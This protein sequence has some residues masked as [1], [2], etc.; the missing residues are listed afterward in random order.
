MTV[1][2]YSATL[3]PFLSTI[4]MST[5]LKKRMSYYT[6]D[7]LTACYMHIYFPELTGDYSNVW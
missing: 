4:G 6:L 7:T 2:K 3:A 5:F 1:A